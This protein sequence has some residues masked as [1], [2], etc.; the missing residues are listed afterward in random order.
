M[1]GRDWP[2]NLKILSEDM[3]T[4][5][6]IRHLMDEKL[7]KN[8]LVHKGFFD[9]L[10]NNQLMDKGKQRFDQI[11]DDMRKNLEPGYSIYVTGHR[12]ATEIH[13]HALLFVSRFL[14]VDSH[15]FPSVV[16]LEALSQPFSQ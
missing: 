3:W 11:I 15:S 7:K 12:Y 16:V 5:D 2:T 1:G 10:F 13:D 4:P 6:R 8:V 9:Y 14:F